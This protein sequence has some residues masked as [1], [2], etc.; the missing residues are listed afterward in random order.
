MSIRL[1]AVV[2]VLA[3]V[4]GVGGSKAETETAAA[5]PVSA[6]MAALIAEATPPTRADYQAAVAN[7]RR[8]LDA[9]VVD[10]VALQKNGVKGKKKLAEILDAYL[11]LYE[12][13]ADAS[14]RERIL[15]RVRD[16]SAATLR[17][18]YHDMRT[19][20]DKTFRENSTSYLRV[21]YLLDKFGLPTNYYRQQIN[22]A[23]P[24]INQHL[25]QRGVSQRMNFA[26]YYDYLGLEKPPLLL[27]QHVEQGLIVNRHP[28]SAYTRLDEYSFTHEIFAAY[29]YGRSKQSSTFREGDVAYVRH[30]LPVLLA[31]CVDRGDYDLGAEHL[32][33][34]TYMGLTDLPIYTQGLR[35]L[36][37]GQNRNGTWGDYEY[38]R[39]RIGDLV[40]PML[41]LHTTL[42]AIQAL[43]EA[44]DG[45]WPAGLVF[46]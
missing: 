36:L 44:F 31:G 8:W 19:V 21:C 17:V 10:P 14:D 35:W 12:N 7:A 4:A 46:E 40:D 9:L 13:V 29:E 2:A 30:T 1:P 28:V 32:S 27:Q 37:N 33:C 16:K 43:V 42:V 22:L 25:E 5:P 38:A 41:Y 20:D 39:A 11:T 45:G 24:R 6:T 15:E 26:F 18:E 34:L 3:V 23:L